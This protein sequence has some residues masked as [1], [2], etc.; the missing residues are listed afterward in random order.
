M[1]PCKPWACEHGYQTLITAMKLFWECP[2]DLL[3][4][5]CDFLS[6]QTFD[7]FQRLPKPALYQASTHDDM[8]P[9]YPSVAPVSALYHALTRAVP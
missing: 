1:A 2:L 4:L 8:N 9:W 3:C 5:N 7:I 6:S